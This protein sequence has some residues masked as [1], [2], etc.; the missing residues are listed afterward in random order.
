[1]IQSQLEQN[2]AGVYTLSD[3]QLTLLQLKIYVDDPGSSVLP[4]NQSE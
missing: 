1:M 3:V 2:A 4:Q